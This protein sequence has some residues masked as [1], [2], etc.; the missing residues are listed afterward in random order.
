MDRILVNCVRNKLIVLMLLLSVAVLVSDSL[1]ALSENGPEDRRHRIARIM[2]SA[3]AL[4][5]LSSQS[6]FLSDLATAWAKVDPIRAETVCQ[7]AFRIVRRVEDDKAWTEAVRINNEAVLWP[8]DEKTEARLW[9]AR[10]IKGSRVVWPLAA[11][12]EAWTP[13]NSTEALKVVQHGV[14][15]ARQ[16]SDSYSQGVALKLLAPLAAVLDARMAEGLAS[17]I[18]ISELRAWAYLQ[19][20]RRLSAV[21][22]KAAA[23][24]YGQA[25]LTASRI[26]APITRIQVLV[27]VATAWSL[28]DRDSGMKIFKDAARQAA[29]IRDPSLSAYAFRLVG[30]GWSRLGS[31]RATELAALIPVDFRIDR[32]MLLLTAAE[33]AQDTVGGKNLLEAALQE[34]MELTSAHE[35]DIALGRVAELMVP[36]DLDRAVD[37]I[38]RIDPSSRLTRSKAL[39]AAALNAFELNADRSI[40]LA[41][42]IKDAGHRIKTLTQLAQMAYAAGEAQGLP[43]LEEAAKLHEDLGDDVSRRNLAL[44]WLGY[45]TEKALDLAAHI[46]SDSEKALAYAGL[47]RR[48]MSM[49]RETEAVK[50]WKR[51]VDLA[52][53]AGAD[54]EK[55][56]AALLKELAE[57]WS[58]VDPVEAGEVFEL[59]YQLTVGR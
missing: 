54:P 44:A 34:S 52:K 33:A 12:A 51:A 53:A 14:V 37:I 15:L 24:H 16:D 58:E 25:F 59:A 19:M 46:G 36:L 11:I 4:E 22:V 50:A 39:S 40:R 42:R 28:L 18:K 55:N 56:G 43:L 2:E 49:G 32:L 20:G 45:S 27:R 57:M 38:D 26:K 35:R 29:T 5:D 9:A 6:L 30:A 7:A 41:G 3:L 47:A 13:L 17:A 1:N 21:D 48:L 23:R 10:V 31:Q 8:P